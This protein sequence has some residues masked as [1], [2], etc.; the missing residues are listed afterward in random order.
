M[1][2]AYYRDKTP[3]AKD[4]ARLSRKITKLTFNGETKRGFEYVS[5]FYVEVLSQ[6]KGESYHIIIYA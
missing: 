6:Y 3:T 4:L 2:E 1:I 5:G